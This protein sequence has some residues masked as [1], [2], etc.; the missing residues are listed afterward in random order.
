VDQVLHLLSK[1]RPFLKQYNYS[2]GA[3]KVEYMSHIVAKDGVQVD[4]KKIE[5]MKD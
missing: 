2:F 4:S 1:H 3:S 5:A